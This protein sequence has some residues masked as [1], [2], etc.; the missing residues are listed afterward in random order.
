MFQVYRVTFIGFNADSVP[1]ETVRLKKTRISKDDE[2]MAREAENALAW[3]GRNI[4]GM[5]LNRWLS[6]I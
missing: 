4:F 3:S 5:S 2:N 6:K 1:H